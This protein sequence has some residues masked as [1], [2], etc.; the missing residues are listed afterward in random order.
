MSDG[1]SCRCREGLGRGSCLGVSWAVGNRLRW[2]P[3]ALPEAACPLW[4]GVWIAQ[5]SCLRMASPMCR[6]VL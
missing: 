1:S 5:L 4:R 6:A 2:C 3:V